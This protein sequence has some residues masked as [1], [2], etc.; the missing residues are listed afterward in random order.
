MSRF[1]HMLVRAALALGVL[2]ASAGA[3]SALPAASGVVANVNSQAI[4]RLVKQYEREKAKLQSVERDRLA[5]ERA[6]QSLALEIERI[7]EGGVTSLERRALEPKL[8]EARRLAEALAEIQRGVKRMER[9]LGRTS[10]SIVR[11][12]DAER[13]A[14][15]R[16]LVVA[17]GA[18]QRA[19][20]EELNELSRAR[21]RYAKPLPR[22]DTSR[23]DTMLEM[24]QLLD[25]PDEMLSLADELDD[26]AARVQARLE[27]LAEQKTKL[28]SQRRLLRRS[29]TFGRQERFFEEADRTRAVATRAGGTDQSGSTDRE[30]M[31]D[32]AASAPP[33]PEAGPR[34]GDA[35]EEGGGVGV[36]A[37]EAGGEADSFDAVDA[38]Q[39]DEGM[40]SEFTSE[41]GQTGTPAPDEGGDDFDS[42]FDGGS[43]VVERQADPDTIARGAY[44]DDAQLDARID[45]LADRERKLERQTKRL[46]RRAKKLRAEANEFE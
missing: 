19:L 11:A 10:R 33:P 40:S 27:L 44:F 9:R 41:D 17:K 6:V 15:E 1:T 29:Q 38:V 37:G 36:T 7:K 16:E 14:L 18:Q 34:D 20:V 3:T 31:S 5:L 45:D 32:A 4:T 43:V 35:L 24:A 39:D 26:E 13:A 42:G 23:I 25:D 22:V 21:Q 30:E 8:Q 46:K 2:T 28:E 12:L